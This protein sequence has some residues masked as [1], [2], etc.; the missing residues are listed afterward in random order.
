MLGA[1]CVLPVIM[2]RIWLITPVLYD[3]RFPCGCPNDMNIF[4]NLNHREI[5]NW[6]SSQSAGRLVDLEQG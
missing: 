3:Q 4:C 2:S 6:T 1:V 5:F